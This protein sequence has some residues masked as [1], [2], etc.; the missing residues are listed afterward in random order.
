MTPESNTWTGSWTGENNVNTDGGLGNSINVTF[1]VL[2]TVQR[3]GKRIPCPGSCSMS[4]WPS[5]SVSSQ[6]YQLL[7]L[8]AVSNGKC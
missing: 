7:L 1:P 8:T 5:D 3:V 4:L 2:I 6:Y